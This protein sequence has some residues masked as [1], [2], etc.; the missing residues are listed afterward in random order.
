ML[1]KRIVS[2]L[3][4]CGALWNAFME[5]RYVSD[6]WDFRLCFQRHFRHEPH[7]LVLED[8]KG[9]YGILPLVY[10]ADTET[11][12]LYPG[13]TWKGKTWLERTPI[14]CREPRA[15]SDLLLESPE[16]TYLRYMEGGEGSALPGVE[17]DETGYLLYPPDLDFDVNEYYKRFS[18]KKLKAIKKEISAILGTRSSWH[19]NRL[20][21]YDLLVEMNL[22]SFGENSYFRDSRFTESFRDIIAFLDRRGWLRMVALEIS[23]QTVA[24]D[25]AAIYKGGYVPFLG[26]THLD[27]RGVAKVMNMHHIEFAMTEG[28]SRVDF[29]CGDFYWKK[30]WHLNPDPLYKFVSPA[31]KEE[32]QPPQEEPEEIDLVMPM[33]EMGAAGL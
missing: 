28:L 21:D 24:V 14:Y 25:L 13:E 5:V 27:F 2:D 15:F 11:Y 4:E 29:L 23:G 8:R 31:L 1:K 22:R 7:F 18:W 3:E 19:I 9:L 12:V 6:L 30:L 10:V 17:V 32:L 26:G 20:S 16:R 33:Q